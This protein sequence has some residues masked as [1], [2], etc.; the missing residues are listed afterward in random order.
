L[1]YLITEGFGF[2]SDFE[3]FIRYS[4]TWLS[5]YKHYHW[6]VAQWI[7]NMDFLVLSLYVF[8]IRCSFRQKSLYIIL[9]WQHEL[10]S[11]FPVLVIIFSV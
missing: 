4:F 2:L 9:L 10:A 7:E 3:L 6:R 5:A 11:N 1:F 8:Y